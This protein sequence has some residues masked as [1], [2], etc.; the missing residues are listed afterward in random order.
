[1]VSLNLQQLIT[2]RIVEGFTDAVTPN[3]LRDL[4]ASVD[5]TA[6]MKKLRWTDAGLDRGKF[7]EIGESAR[8]CG[9]RV[10]ALAV[11]RACWFGS[12]SKMVI[13]TGGTYKGEKCDG[14]SG[15]HATDR[16]RMMW[17]LDRVL[18]QQLCR[19]HFI[20]S[21]GKTYYQEK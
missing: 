12:F 9:Q 10:E 6:A 18:N 8:L 5:G 14:S 1:M 2:H 11:G 21:R 7:S 4:G 13:E 16:H 3:I 20:D 19:Y 15:C 17:F